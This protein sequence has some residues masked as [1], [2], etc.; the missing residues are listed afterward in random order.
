MKISKSTL[1][2][3]SEQG[4]RQSTEGDLDNFVKETAD[5][6][7]S[8]GKGLTEVCDYLHALGA[9]GL[10]WNQEMS[11]AYRNT[12][13]REDLEALWPK[14]H[15]LRRM[16]DCG[17]HNCSLAC[18]QCLQRKA[19]H[20]KL[21]RCWQLLEEEG[22]RIQRVIENADLILFHPPM[23][24]PSRDTVLRP[25]LLGKCWYDG[26]ELE[27]VGGISD[28]ATNWGL[29]QRFTEF[30][31]HLS[32]HQSVTRW[33]HLNDWG[34][35]SKPPTVYANRFEESLRL[36][37]NV[38]LD[39]LVGSTLHNLSE[40]LR[41]TMYYL[42]NGE[43]QAPD[44]ENDARVSEGSDSPTLAMGKYFSEYFH[45][46][47]EPKKPRSRN[48][49]N[50]SN[51]SNLRHTVEHNRRLTGS[52]SAHKEEM[53]ERQRKILTEGLELEYASPKIPALKD[54]RSSQQSTSGP[55]RESLQTCPSPP[56]R[57]RQLSHGFKLEQAN[58]A[59]A[60]SIYVNRDLKTEIVEV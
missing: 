2:R 37:F 21:H 57:G 31:K 36:Y 25:T 10:A 6:L 1:R 12:F 48:S 29:Y 54:L 39:N 60:H 11:E 41:P 7:E 14:I 46:K 45:D 19:N 22:Q 15:A 4:R 59:P 27:L 38:E 58:S 49:S 53:L 51:S 40:P 32:K 50:L 5:S 33:C 8:I 30:G 43:A 35:S 28:V 13:S 17:T 9:I 16:Y 23:P 20:L 44:F 24:K 42:N 26:Q 47:E 56:S 18:I 55:P 3:L 34:V 52:M